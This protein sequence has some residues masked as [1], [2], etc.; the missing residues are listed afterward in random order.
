MQKSNKRLETAKENHHENWSKMTLE[1]ISGKYYQIGII[2]EI[3]SVG[4]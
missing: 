2:E 4:L 3:L 1:G